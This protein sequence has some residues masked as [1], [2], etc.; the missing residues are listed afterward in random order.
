MISRSLASLLLV[1]ALAGCAGPGWYAQ[2][3]SGHYRL[4]S[5]R[6][7]IDEALGSGQL[8]PAMAERVEQAV[9]MIAFA[10]SRL[11]LDAGESYRQL[12]LTG[13]EAVSW[14]VVA[15]PEF[16]LEAKRWCF[17]VS[18]CVPYRGYFEADGAEDF[19]AR[20]EARGYDVTVSPAIA[21]STLGWFHDPLLD[22]MFRYD[23]AQLA[24]FIFHELAHRK[25][26]VR[27]DTAFSEAYAS[28]VEEAGA[29]AWLEGSGQTDLADGWRVREAASRDFNELLRQVRRD[30][31]RIYAS[32][33]EDHH[34]RKLKA[35]RF[36]TL[37]TEYRELVEQRWGGRDFY[38]GWFERGANNAQLALAESY[39]GGV[40]AFRKLFE[41]AGGDWARF[42]ELAEN[43]AELGRDTRRDWLRQPCGD[44]ASAGDL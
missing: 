10:E 21:Y 33:A 11:Q 16:S 25:L 20:L 19:A 13:K 3:V 34:K 31:D 12:V 18:G 36:G 17:L 6:Q 26:Y 23:D 37:K 5:E 15:A 14:N 39:Q 2:A 29:T 27:G 32:E 4:M 22:T 38:S 35:E 42:H 30:L 8:E 44:I 41:L 40:C 24:A 7:D 9:E 1:L 28:F 43:R